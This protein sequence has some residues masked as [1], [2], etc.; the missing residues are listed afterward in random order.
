MLARRHVFV[1]E[2]A[3]AR[4][5]V[6]AAIAELQEAIRTT[7]KH[8]DGSYKRYIADL[9]YEVASLY[10]LKDVA[11]AQRWLAA[12]LKIVPDHAEARQLRDALARGKDRPQADPN[13]AATSSPAPLSPSPAGS[14]A[15]PTTP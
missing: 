10:A 14:S 7:P 6:D 4:G 8:I 12:V 15:P 5:D 13:G 11:V 1:A 2:Q 3:R 9:S